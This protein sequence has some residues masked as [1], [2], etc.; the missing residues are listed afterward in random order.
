MTNIPLV[1][2]DFINFYVDY[3]AN[4]HLSQREAIRLIG[5][6][7]GKNATYIIAWAFKQMSGERV[8]VFDNGQ[9][10]YI[11]MNSYYY[12]INTLCGICKIDN[13]QRHMKGF[14]NN[15]EITIKEIDEIMVECFDK[16]PS[17]R[18]TIARGYFKRRF[19]P[20]PPNMHKPTSKKSRQILG[21]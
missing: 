9:H 20:I 15:V 18:N 5:N 17:A 3:V 21:E 14:D 10:A 6:K 12:D 19:I 2:Q 4:R 11:G 1:I 7:L 8:Y 13:S 16:T